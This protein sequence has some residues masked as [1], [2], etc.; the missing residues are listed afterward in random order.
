MDLHLHATAGR[1]AYRPSGKA[2]LL[3]LLPL[4]ALAFLVASFLAI[5]LYIIYLLGFYYIVV[6]PILAVLPVAALTVLAVHFGHCRSRRLAGTIGA[7]ASALLYLGYYQMGVFD[8]AGPEGLARLDLL[9]SYIA[10]RMNTDRIDHEPGPGVPDDDAPAAGAGDEAPAGAGDE[11]PA[12]GLFHRVMNWCVFAAELLLVF[13]VTV[14]LAVRRASRPYC[15][16]CRCWMDRE[17]ANHPP[18]HLEAILEALGG[19]P[20]RFPAISAGSVRTDVPHVALAAEYCARSKHSPED[21]DS[22]PVYFSV[23]TA[24]GVNRG[25]LTNFDLAPGKLLVRQVELSEEELE[26]LAPSFPKLAAVLGKIGAAVESTREEPP[27]SVHATGADCATCERVDSGGEVLRAGNKV[28]GTLAALRPLGR[29]LLSLLL[30]VVVVLLLLP[31]DGDPPVAQVLLLSGLAL[32][33][34]VAIVVQLI[35]FQRDTA[36]ARDRFYHRITRDRLLSR[37]RPL[38]DPDDPEAFF[39]EI[40]PRENWAKLKLETAVD[41][42]FL[43]VDTRGRRLLFEGDLN[44]YSIPGRA[45]LSSA[46]ETFVVGQGAPA[47]VTYYPVIV[48]AR[49][50]G[51][52]PLVLSFILLNKGEKHSWRHRER[53]AE[54]LNDRIG[55]LLE[56]VEA[57]A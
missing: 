31:G 15:E 53:Q 13:S 11:A 14:V 57:F 16:R 27:P 43:L 19:D 29:V 38:V 55:Q 48:T 34:V 24:T 39:V 4:S 46:V 45:I 41:M 6:V 20:A 35:C 36:A 49:L 42:G 7:V 1:A 40:T 52:E 28:R 26:A 50:A 8:G 30:T 47:A 18:E 51:E 21:A 23:K 2:S 25:A 44:R 9:P 3:R 22:F 17:F 33:G 37:T 12:L 32:V 5:V 10:F 54:Q 56:T